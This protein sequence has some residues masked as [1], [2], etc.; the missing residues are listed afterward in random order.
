MIDSSG[1]VKSACKTDSDWAEI[2]I[3]RNIV[4]AYSK[5]KNVGASVV[6]KVNGAPQ[7]SKNSVRTGGYSRYAPF[8]RPYIHPS[9]F[10]VSNEKTDF[11]LF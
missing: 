7:K 5:E 2:K 11:A 9:F 10:E 3:V 1:S 4:K 6:N 8:T